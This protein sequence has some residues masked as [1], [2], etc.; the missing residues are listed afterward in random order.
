MMFFCLQRRKN[1]DPEESIRLFL[2]SEKET[3][4]LEKFFVQ[5]LKQFP[6]I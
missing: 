3:L 1:R 5:I 2:K 6:Y 4:D